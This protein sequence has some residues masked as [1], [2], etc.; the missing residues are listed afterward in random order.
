MKGINEIMAEQNQA[1]NS[2]S[3]AIDF[4]K[5]ISEE[6]IVTVKFTKKDGTDRIMKCTLNFNRIPKESRPNGVKLIDI[7]KKI[8]KNK[9]LSVFDLEKMGWRSIPFERTEWLKVDNRT[10][11]IQKIKDV[12]RK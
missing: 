2:I 5:R 12:M 11:S 3:N 9:I 1:E 10:Y 6:D 7:L 4:L 8:Q